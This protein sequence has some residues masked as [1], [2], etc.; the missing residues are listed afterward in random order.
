MGS[1]SASTITT[2]SCDVLVVGAGP[3]GAVAARVLA[4]Q[5]AQVIML[6]SLSSMRPKVGESLPGAI[7]PLLQAA[8]LHSWFAQS[9]PL[10]NPGNLASWGNAQLHATDAIRDPYG[11]GW[12]LDRARFEQCLQNAAREAGVRF[13]RA[14]LN[15]VTPSEHGVE[16]QA[17]EATLRAKWI[18]DASGKARTVARQLGGI[19]RRDPP[20]LALCAWYPDGYDDTRSLIEAAPSG[21]WYSAGLPERNR[22]FAFFTLPER[23]K[24]LLQQPTGF[25]DQLRTTRYIQRGLTGKHA[26]AHLPVQVVDAAGSHLV[27]VCGPR[28]VAA[29]DAA[30]SFD[31]LSSQGLYNALYT[32]LRSAEAVSAALQSG[33][34]TLL[35]QYAERVAEI[36]YVYQSEV[37]HYYRQEQRWPDDP[38]WATHHR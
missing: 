5:G 7:A 24:T 16:V 13:L 31:P 21:W 22:L 36:R 26:V 34:Q 29:G 19:A 35:A 20:L 30:L 2:L 25:L 1:V 33:N 23:A 12:H 4:R 8:G 15:T 10:P 37:R 6:D 18:I 32:G 17:G 14:H 28:W 27:S 38:F 9:Q 3:A 11:C